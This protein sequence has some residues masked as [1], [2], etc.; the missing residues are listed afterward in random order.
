M[1]HCEACGGELTVEEAHY[2]EDRCEAC[3]RLVHERLAAWRE[4]AHDPAMDAGQ[5]FIMPEVY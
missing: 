4:G 1:T 3:E 5:F 2:Y